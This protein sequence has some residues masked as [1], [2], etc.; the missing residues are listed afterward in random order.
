MQ[1]HALRTVM[2][3]P[4]IEPLVIAEIESLLLELPLKVPV[5][6]G[7]EDD[8]R[9]PRPQCPDHL[10]PELRLGPGPGTRAPRALEH[11]VDEKHRH[12]AA[13]AVAL[14]GNLAHR[15]GRNSAQPGM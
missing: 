15:F 5:G 6:L 11:L 12:V 13:H 8:L 3:E 1:S 7:Y 4:I 2:G 14:L 9:M 10:Q